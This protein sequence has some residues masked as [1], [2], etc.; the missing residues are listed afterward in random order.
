MRSLN[1]LIAMYD[2]H[3]KENPG[4]DRLGAFFCRKVMPKACSN[5]KAMNDQEAET[6]IRHWLRDRGYT[7]HLPISDSY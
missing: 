7:S 2:Q 3:L 1:Q 4:G 6:A 5:I